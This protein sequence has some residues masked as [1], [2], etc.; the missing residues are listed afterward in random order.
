VEA[1]R[2]LCAAPLIIF[3]ILLFAA[4]RQRV[5]TGAS[6]SRWMTV[7]AR[8]AL[9]ASLPAGASILLAAFGRAP[10]IEVSVG[11]T[12][13]AAATCATMLRQLRLRGRGDVPQL[14]EE[15]PIVDRV[16][17]VAMRMGV[18]PP[19]VRTFGTFGALQAYAAVGSAMR[20]TLFL[21]DGILQ[22]L[23]PEEADAV[24]GH[25]LAHVLNGS[26]WLM[27]AIWT[28]S[29]A[30]SVLLAGLAAPGWDAGGGEAVFTL[31]FSLLL[32]LFAAI[33]RSNERW[34]DMRGA[35]AVG[36]ANAVRGLDKAHT[37]FPLPNDGWLAFAVHAVSTHP[38]RAARLQ[39]LRRR[40]PESERALLDAGEPSRARIQDAAATAA[41]ALWISCIGLGLF[42]L[43]LGL[44]HA[45]VLLALP[46]AVQ[47]ALAMLVQ[48][49]RLRRARRLLPLRA[50]GRSLVWGGVLLL[51]ASPLGFLALPVLAR[52]FST[53]RHLWM[54][55]AIAALSVL[56]LAGLAAALIGLAVSMG[57]KQRFQ[58]V[59]GALGRN[60]FAGARALARGKH[61]SEKHPSLRHLAAYAALLGGDRERGI[62]ELRELCRDPVRVPASLLL[63]AAV[64]RHQEPETSLELSRRGLLKLKGDAVARVMLASSL[65]AR[66]RLDEAEHEASLAE[67]EPGQIGSTA[68][69]IRARILLA[70]GDTSRAERLVEDALRL[71]AGEPAAL[72]ARAHVWAATRPPD[73]AVR[74]ADDAFA[75]ARS[76]PFALL[77]E[78]V[79]EL[80]ELK[81]RR[82][83]V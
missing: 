26:I 66:G 53:D 81:A 50:P 77:D 52:T 15:G 20:P 37:A 33:N 82:K 48:M 6:I 30:L 7:S 47:I 51:L 46:G 67:R 62:A 78:E 69:S 12:L 70:R 22:R 4:H 60:D 19:P 58:D 43:H 27:P 71:S 83:A 39:A 54:I 36:F 14:V 49:R 41:G 23:T 9:L 8:L 68:L 63:L 80:R 45:Q 38:P 16:R 72:I 10:P 44:S 40:A 74:A 42:A 65:R 73:E 59:L 55:C 18:T 24:I 64:L 32:P 21:S 61:G 31:F 17:D 25:E 34:C 13:L 28:S 57:F 11:A 35:Q 1:T 3:P 5:Q 79:A 56:P 2:F 76:N 29:A 75:A